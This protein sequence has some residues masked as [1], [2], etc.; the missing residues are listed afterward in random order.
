MK[1]F[2]CGDSFCTSDPEYGKNWSELLADQFNGE[3]INLGRDGASN[4]HIYQQVKYALDN[5]CDYLIYHAT[6]SIRQ[7]FVVKQDHASRDSLDRYMD[8][9]LPRNKSMICGSWG[10]PEKNFTDI[11]RTEQIDQIRNFFLEYI[12]FASVI[13]KNYIF[14]MHTLDMIKNSNLKKWSWSRGGFEHPKF[15]NVLEWD[16]SKYADTHCPID[17]WQYYDRSIIRPYYHVQDKD[18]LKNLCNYYLNLL[19]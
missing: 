2:I 10:A 6:S 19:H 5:R 17:L 1:L 16:F 9:H 4:Y 3:V 8:I 7:E 13:E 18:V 14:I 15:G 12:D 11:L